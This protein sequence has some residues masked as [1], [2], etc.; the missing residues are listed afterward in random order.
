MRSICTC[1]LTINLRLRRVGYGACPE[2]RIRGILERIFYE[3]VSDGV[4]Q[5]YWGKEARERYRWY[6]QSDAWKAKRKAV[7]QAYLQ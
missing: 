7:L 5:K 6:L 3:M 4:A 2:K 1:V